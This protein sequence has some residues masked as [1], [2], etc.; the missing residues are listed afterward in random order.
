[1]RLAA[2]PLWGS[3]VAIFLIILWYELLAFV[4]SVSPVIVLVGK[5]SSSSF[6]GRCGVQRAD[7]SFEET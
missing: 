6:H 5:I 4:P 1:M 7:L 3:K 2:G